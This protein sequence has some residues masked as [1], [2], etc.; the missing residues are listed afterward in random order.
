MGWYRFRHVK[1]SWL[2]LIIG[3]LDILIAWLFLGANTTDVCDDGF[4]P[5][6]H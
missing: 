4:H 6:R 3:I 2:Q 5:G 1:G